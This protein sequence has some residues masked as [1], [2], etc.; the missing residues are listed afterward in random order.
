MQES[1]HEN[2]VAHLPSALKD[3]EL[4]AAKRGR[5]HKDELEYMDAIRSRWFIFDQGG[6]FRSYWDFIVMFLA[7]Y[8]CLWTPLTVSFDYAIML[9]K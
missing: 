2:Q 8:N 7:L 4:K 9:D 3:I 6:D 5:L 1:K